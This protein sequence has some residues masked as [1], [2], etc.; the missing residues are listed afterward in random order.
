MVN[1]VILQ[2]QFGSFF[3]CI[4]NISVNHSCFPLNQFP[5][6]IHL[7]TALSEQNG[8]FSIEDILDILFHTKIRNEM[9]KLVIISPYCDP[10]LIIIL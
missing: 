1:E 4:T 6:D 8:A 3:K 2:N 10:C 5:W 7:S 9:A